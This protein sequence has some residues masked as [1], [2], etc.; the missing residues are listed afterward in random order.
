VD[1]D[2]LADLGSIEAAMPSA[3]EP[4][5]QLAR[6]PSATKRRKRT[7]VT[8]PQLDP[9]IL[10]SIG[11]VVVAIAT[12]VIFFF[13][14]ATPPV[15]S[16]G[17]GI[18]MAGSL[19]FGLAKV[20]LMPE[21]W[22]G[23]G[24]LFGFGISGV[25]IL[26]MLFGAFVLGERE[27]LPANKTQQSDADSPGSL[28]PADIDNVS[29]DGLSAIEQEGPQLEDAIASDAKWAFG[30]DP[31][32]P[33]KQFDLVGN[34][35]IVF[36]RG[37]YTKSRLAVFSTFKSPYVALGDMRLENASVELWDYATQTRLGS[38]AGKLELDRPLISFDGEYLAGIGEVGI[39]EKFVGVWTFESGERIC[40]IRPQTPPR[41]VD[42]SGHDRLLVFTGPK[43]TSYGTNTTL[44]SDIETWDVRTGKKVQSFHIP[45][46][47]VHYSDV[48]FSPGRKYLAVRGRESISV[49]DLASGE[50]VGKA[51]FARQW[52]G[53]AISFSPDGKE[54]LLL[55]SELGAAKIVCWDTATGKIALQLTLG[56]FTGEGNIYDRGEQQVE[57]FD[58]GRGW[59]LAGRALIDRNS[60]KEIWTAPERPQLNPR[61]IVGDRMLMISRGKDYAELT[62][63]QIPFDAPTY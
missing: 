43:D 60:G 18:A 19:L 29:T 52:H 5:S 9:R 10:A 2:P 44:G 23:E 59:L 50:S 11:F 63:P 20:Q 61:K 17:I 45:E 14:L 56:A 21:E 24:F 41:F 30:V 7:K 42:F 62:A 35:S 8:L 37:T 48:A 53:R 46:R 54:L 22:R 15:L 27:Q 26:V 51:P 47:P 36:G 57:W 28:S 49:Y 39:G 12:S 3:T 34:I 33:D 38:I 1:D 4:R 58:D 13:G 32:A 25:G 6:T 31:P 16:I 40:Q 55:F